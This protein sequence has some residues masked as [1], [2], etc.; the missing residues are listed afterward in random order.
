LRI[1][2]VVP[3][4]ALSGDF[5]TILRLLKDKKMNFSTPNSNV[6]RL[7]SLL[8]VLLAAAPL[9]QAQTFLPPDAAASCT[10]PATT[11]NGWFAS[12][13]PAANGAV[14]PANSITFQSSTANPPSPPNTINCNFY[15]WSQQMFLWVTSPAGKQRVFSGPTFYTL[16]ANN[17]LV[18]NGLGIISGFSRAGKAINT[19]VDQAGGSP[20]LMAQ[21]NQMVFYS[22]HVNNVYAYFAKQ[23][24]SPSATLAF[25]TTQA[26]LN[27]ILAAAGKKSLPGQNALAIELKLSWVEATDADKANFVTMN[28]E[29]PTFTQ[30]S[31][32]LWTQSG[33]KKALLKMIGMHVVGSVAGHPEMI[34]A[35]YEYKNNA[36]NAAYSYINNKNA[37]VPVSQPVSQ[38]MLLAA[39]NAAAPF[40]VEFMKFVPANP[41]ATPPVPAA[42]ITA[43]SPNTIGASNTVRLF[44]W[45]ANGDVVPNPLVTSAAQSNTEVISIN[46]NVL[47]ML[48]G[49]DVRKNYLFMGA[50]WTDGGFA[51]TSSNQVGTSSLANTTMETYD[52]VAKGTNNCFG[53]H[54][55]ASGL[56]TDPKQAATTAVSHIFSSMTTKKV[57]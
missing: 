51:P 27:A 41:T 34:W 2:A 44:P 30:N 46:N 45:G 13:T 54:N 57:K 49:N 5:S 31:T 21:G 55:T 25:P 15:Q 56:A 40:N 16:N 17:A 29:I 14:V 48:P 1:A 4:Q 39:N 47:S 20:V 3:C 26:Q 33:K 23:N 9:P 12:G 22:V 11:F 42:T 19:T 38:N 32:T 52:T 6:L 28:A 43:V 24:R 35:T 53:C 10:V 37:T 8:A 36:V 50:T 7:S 18:P